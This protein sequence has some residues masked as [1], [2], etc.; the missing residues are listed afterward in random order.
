MQI[1]GS[2][3]A[4]GGCTK[5]TLRAGCLATRSGWTA[6]QN[7]DRRS[8]RLARGRAFDHSAYR[9]GTLT[10]PANNTRPRLSAKLARD[11][12]FAAAASLKKV[13]SSMS[14]SNQQSVDCTLVRERYA[15]AA[16]A[17]TS[18]AQ[19]T[20]PRRGAARV[21]T[22]VTR[23]S[24]PNRADISRSSRYVELCVSVSELITTLKT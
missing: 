6:A 11:V 23:P 9:L 12:S 16:R 8:A 2:V 15:C 17:S 4:A 24:T 22:S 5:S 18:P 10:F 19:L 20:A 21:G 13:C 1:G 3:A 7:S 14:F